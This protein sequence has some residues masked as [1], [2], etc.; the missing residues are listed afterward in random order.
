MCL[1]EEMKEELSGTTAVC[2]LIK[3][4]KLYCVCVM[5]FLLEHNDNCLFFFVKG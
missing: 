1:D 2:V 5:L 4:K 3:D